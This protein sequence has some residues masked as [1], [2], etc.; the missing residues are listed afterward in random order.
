MANLLTIPNDLLRQ[1]CR[2]VTRNDDLTGILAEM[3]RI[4]VENK[5]IGLSANQIG[6]LLRV[7]SVNTLFLLNPKWRPAP[8]CAVVTVPEACL[9]V[10]DTLVQCQRYTSVEVEYFTPTW[11]SVTR[12]F[13]GEEAIT[14]QH[15]CDHLDGILIIDR[16]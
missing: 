3:R 8:G 6:E 4:Q 10:P 14:V 5:G 11:Q 2:K 15:E 7:I 16:N 12:T 1:T 13:G 9:S